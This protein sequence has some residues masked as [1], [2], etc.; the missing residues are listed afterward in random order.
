VPEVRDLR[1]VP[2]S[3]RQRAPEEVLVEFCGAAIRVASHRIGVV[4]D[5][6]ARSDD[7][8]REQLRGQVAG[9]PR[10]PGQYPACVALHQVLAPAASHIESAAS[11]SGAKGSS[12]SCNQSAPRAPSDCRPSRRTGGNEARRDS[13]RWVHDR[14]RKRVN[15][16]RHSGTTSS[17]SSASWR[18]CGPWSDRLARRGSRGSGARFA[19]RYPIGDPSTGW[20]AGHPVFLEFE[21]LGIGLVEHPQPGA[22]CQIAR[23]GSRA[24]EFTAGCFLA[25]ARLTPHGATRFLV[26]GQRC[27]GSK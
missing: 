26:A 9:V 21:Q 20:I 15:H 16:R 13:V 22:D 4:G 27:T 7:V 25:R 19:R 14:R 24:A 12:W 2:G 10:D 5:E 3:S 8:D 11:P 18:N 23:S 17:A 6:V 1:S